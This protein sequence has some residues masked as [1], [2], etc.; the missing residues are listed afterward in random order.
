MADPADPVPPVPTGAPPADAAPGLARLNT[1]APHDARRLLREVCAARAWIDAVA[2]RL[3]CRDAD[4]LY[5]ASDRATTALVPADLAEALSG[6]AAIGSP[7]ERDEA[8]Q[9]EQAGV[10]GADD[11][12]LAE[13]AD[14]NREYRDRFGHVFLICATGRSAEDMLAALRK[15]LGNDAATERGTTREELRRINRIRLERLVQA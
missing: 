2:A 14:A 1:A 5:A 4:E 3:P 15:R 12:L 11:S 9:R 6:H 13:L 8:S 7:S 10:R